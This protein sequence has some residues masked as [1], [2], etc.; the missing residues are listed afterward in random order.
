MPRIEPLPADV[1]QH[2][3]KYME[4]RFSHKTPTEKATI[5]QGLVKQLRA[6]PHR[7]Q[8][9]ME[10]VQNLYETNKDLVQASEKAKE[11]SEYRER[12]KET[13]SRNRTK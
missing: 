1:K 4:I 3:D 10:K 12:L 5:Y 2:V 8:E 11:N 9:F 13:M 6:E 7:Q